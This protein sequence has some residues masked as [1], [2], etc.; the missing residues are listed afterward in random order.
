M[1]ATDNS[2]RDREIMAR[3]LVLADRARFVAAPNPH[4]GC[5]L[6][7]DGRIVGE[8]QTQR[9]GDAHAEVMALRAAGAAAAGATVYVTLEPCSHHG[10]TPPCTEALID[11]GV[12]RVVVAIQDPNPQVSGR[13]LQQLREAGI[14]VETGLLA[15]QAEQ[16][17]AG[18][19]ARMR[20]GRGRVRAKLAMSMDGRTAMASGESQWITGPAARADVQLLRAASCAIVT[21]SGTVLADDCAL[22]VRPESFADRLG[23]AEPPRERRPLRV[24]LDSRRRVPATARVLSP[25]TPTLL[26]HAAGAPTPS[27]PSHVEQRAIPETQAGLA[28]D[29]AMQV[30]AARECNEILVESGSVLTGSLLQA[31]LVDE[32]ILY[33]APC[34]LGNLARP[35]LQL[36][37]DLMSEKIELSPVDERRVGNDWRFTL[38]PLSAH[39]TAQDKE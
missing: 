20:R 21:G 6:L 25:D 32:L 18:F 13:G 36:P 27:L 29:A 1:I 14:Q 12:A 33:M 22:T 7:N 28:L 15:T 16:M 35:L 8:G 39:T 2:V 34:L 17:I 37:L 11:A 19:V 4:V 23:E 26:L 10:R 5:V 3:A 30:L 9:A 31:G 24:V 38:V